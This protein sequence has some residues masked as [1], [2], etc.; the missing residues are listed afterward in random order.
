TLHTSVEANTVQELIA[1]AKAKPRSLNV[2]LMTPSSSGALAA[3]LFKILTHTDMVSV[4][5]KGGG[6]TMLALLA[7][8]VQL[9]FAT[10]PDVMGHL[11][12]GK[13]K[14][15]GTTSKERLPYL[16]NVQ[17]FAEAGIKDFQTAP[18]Y[19]LIAPAKTPVAVIDLLHKEVVEALKV[20]SV[21]ERIAASGTDVVGN[22]PKEF[23]EQIRRELEQ[24]EKVIKAVGMKAD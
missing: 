7:G 24:N 10:P 21:R 6:P 8:Q 22:S 17:T 4:P 12:G 14:V 3:E 1:L 19:G 18:W 9:V 15:I 23:A 2:A 11:K 13:L 5:F 20:P 16:P